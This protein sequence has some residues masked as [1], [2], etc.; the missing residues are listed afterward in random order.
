VV[1]FGHHLISDAHAECVHPHQFLTHTLS[2]LNSS[3]HIFSA[4]FEW[5]FSKFWTFSLMLN[6]HLRN[7]CVC[8]KYAS[9]PD[10]YAQ[11]THQFLI[12]MLRVHISSWCV[13]SAMFLWDCFYLFLHPAHWS[14]E[15]CSFQFFILNINKVNFFNSF[16]ILRVIKIN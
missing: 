4:F 9:V 11:Q 6:I 1:V 15:F 8:S 13:F 14:H 7:W 5:T 3:L 16:D 10:A 2:A 12:L